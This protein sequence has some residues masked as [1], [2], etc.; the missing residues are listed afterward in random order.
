MKRCDNSK[1]NKPIH[2]G[3]ERVDV[4]FSGANINEKA[5]QILGTNSLDFCSLEC[6]AEY[7]MYLKDKKVL[8][9]R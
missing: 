3:Q 1:C 6:F 4:T 9:N 5:M 8:E 7:L 2:L